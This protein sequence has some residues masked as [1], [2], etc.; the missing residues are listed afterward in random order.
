MIAIVALAA[1]IG[2]WGLIALLHWLAV[3]LGSG[4]TTRF[5]PGTLGSVLMTLAKA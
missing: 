1:L 3:M 2:G 4:L 5:A